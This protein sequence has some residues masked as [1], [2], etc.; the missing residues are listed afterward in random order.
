MERIFRAED[1]K[2]FLSAN[3]CLKYERKCKLQESYDVEQCKDISISEEITFDQF[4]IRTGLIDQKFYYPHTVNCIVMAFAKS[5]YKCRYGPIE[6][7]PMQYIIDFL[8]YTDFGDRYIWRGFGIKTASRLF[9]NI[10]LAFDIDL[11]PK[12]VLDRGI[13]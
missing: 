7:A 13:Y 11:W 12:Y 8:R 2:E 3:E 5:K 9:F 1:G 10:S 4:L 6:T